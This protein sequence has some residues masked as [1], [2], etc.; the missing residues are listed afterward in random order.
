MAI[1]YRTGK[2]CIGQRGRYYIFKDNINRSYGYVKDE[3]Q[4]IVQPPFCD[5]LSLYGMLK[6]VEGLRQDDWEEGM[7]RME[8]FTRAAND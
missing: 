2:E 3:G 4:D 7:E 8:G 6:H 5:W 1:A